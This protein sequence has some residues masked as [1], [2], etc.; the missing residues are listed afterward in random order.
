MN[1]YLK[2]LGLIPPPVE[3]L[4]AS[5]EFLY[6][7]ALRRGD[8]TASREGALV[9]YTGKYTG[10]IHEAKAF[11][12]EPG[13]EKKI[14]WGK[15]NHPCDEALFQKLKKKIAAHLN[16]QSFFVSDAFAGADPD[17]RLSLRVVTEK[18][19]YALFTGSMFLGRRQGAL[20]VLTGGPELT[21]LHAPSLSLDPAVDGT[22]G[23]ACILIHL[24]ENLILI[25]GTGYAGEIKKSVFTVMNYRMPE[26][27]V[28]PLHSAANY[29]ADENDC[30]LFFGLSGTGKTT[31][32]ADPGRTLIGDDEHGW[33]DH[34]VFNFEGGCYAKAIRLSAEGEPEIFAACQR[35]GTI[36]ENVPLDP[37]T[38][39]VDFQSDR[40]TENTRAIYPIEF[41]PRMT[42]KGVG[43][44][45]KHILM[46]ACDAFGVLPPISRLTPDQAVY[47]FLSGYTAKVAGT[48]T[49]IK[50]PQAVFSACF[51]AP[52]MPLAPTVYAG[53]LRDK[54]HEHG[55][56]VWLVNTGWA[57][58]GY[59]VGK[60]MPLAVTRALVRGVLSGVLNTAAFQRDSIFGT[61]IPM[62]CPGVDAVLLNPRKA[63]SDPAAYEKAARHLAELFKKNFMEVAAGLMPELAQAGPII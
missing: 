62:A 61:E 23:D 45:P 60:R 7:E 27:G 49:G 22:P 35:R 21:I 43:G 34:G 40:I 29:G 24:G 6:N 1:E 16:R 51:G 15:V 56:S 14:H 52:F 36:L 28:L 9:L 54:I 12:R 26:Q 42:P 63:W 25:A 46:L 57:G 33:S 41:I 50:T 18:A 48:E 59:G 3:H 53:L 32:S 11:V 30:A 44:H 47:H 19:V 17:C 4:N 58:G 38:R 20:P 55:T 10:R 13:S 5:A 37:A 39:A 2:A 31:L 8:C